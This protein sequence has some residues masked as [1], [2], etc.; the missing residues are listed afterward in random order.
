MEFSL[1]IDALIVVLLVATIAYA[2]VL[3]RKLGVLRDGKSEMEALIASFSESTERAGSGVESLKREAGRSGEALQSKVEAARGLVDD[4]GFLIETGT[5][6]AERLDGGVGAARVR[7]AAGL[8]A[9]RAPA[10][11]AQAPQAQAPQAQAQQAQAARPA[12][13][14]AKAE[15]GAASNSIPGDTAGG[16]DLAEAESELLK[17]LQG[18]R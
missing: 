13:A 1:I 3:N 18:M 9:E 7:P 17:A 14:A 8:D 16:P 2:A 11:R 6:L 5:R 12:A 4:L 15:T 10:L